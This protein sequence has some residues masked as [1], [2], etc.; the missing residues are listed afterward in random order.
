MLPRWAVAVLVYAILIVGA[1]SLAAHPYARGSAD[2]GVLVN[3]DYR[4]LYFSPRDLTMALTSDNGTLLYANGEWL[5]VN[6]SSTAACSYSGEVALAGS[7][8]GRP[9]LAI[10]SGGRALYYV[11][12][13]SGELTALSC[14][15]RAIAAGGIVNS[16]PVP[17]YNVIAVT[18]SDGRLAAYEANF[19]TY[20]YPQSASA[21]GD[22][23]VAMTFGNDYAVVIG[24]RDP[25]ALEY[26]FNV[27]LDYITGYEGEPLAGGII[28]YR[29]EEYAALILNGTAY[30]YDVDAS[31]AAIAATLNG[32]AVYLRPPAG[33]AS[34]MYTSGFK[35]GAVTTAVMDY[36]FTL[37]GISAYMHG[38]EFVGRLL[39]PAEGY[40]GIY[41][42]GTAEGYLEANG[43]VIGWVASSRP[44]VTVPQLVTSIAVSPSVYP[45]QTTEVGHY[46]AA[47]R[48]LSA[49]GISFSVVKLDYDIY[50]DAVGYSVVAIIIGTLMLAFAS[51][52]H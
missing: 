42:N 44:A 27:T 16:T 30:L 48:A 21:L 22:G 8:G 43:S 20:F 37:T 4:L 7:L 51:D 10:V 9:A 45:L 5:E 24:P 36:P 3:G 50:Y 29:S 12:N 46:E 49:P 33:W 11:I 40:V 38:V 2:W 17:P 1:V 52:R 6:M 14:S 15:G 26:P 39:S 19:T 34:V 31:A 25:R 28:T 35:P 32:L 41:V 18:L 23:D 13:V 47:G